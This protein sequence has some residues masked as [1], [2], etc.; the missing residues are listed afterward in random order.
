[1]MPF[2]NDGTTTTSFAE[3]QDV[4]DADQRLFEANEGLTDDIVEHLL[5]RSTT[6]ILSLIR[7]SDW[8]RDLYLKKSTNP[9]YQTRADV[10]EVDI[11]KIIARQ[12]DFTDLCVYYA[13]WNYILPKV[14]DFS[15]EDNAERAK[16]GF[17]TGKFQYLFDE[18]INSG[19]WYD[20]SGDG[21][22]TSNEKMPGNYSLKRIV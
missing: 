17:Y 6:R 5:V 8:W 4:V 18:L 19:D 13:M 10:P 20:Y 12:D 15:K 2:I 3:Y 11:E 9:S 1:M 21:N 7:A 16:I 22:I 14:A